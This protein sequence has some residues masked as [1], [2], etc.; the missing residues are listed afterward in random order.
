MRQLESLL[1]TAV[2]ALSTS[3]TPALAVWNPQAVPG[4]TANPLKACSLLTR[5]EVKKVLPW[6]PQLDQF[7]MKNCRSAPPAPPVGIQRSSSR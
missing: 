6:A 1:L 4:A 5:D 2:V 7:P 3:L